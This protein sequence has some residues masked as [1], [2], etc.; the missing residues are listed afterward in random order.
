M[1]NQIENKKYLSNIVGRCWR[2]KNVDITKQNT[3]IYWI[4]KYMR[5]IISDSGSISTAKNNDVLFISN[6]L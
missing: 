6:R 5:I 1:K 4:F 3:F 2:L